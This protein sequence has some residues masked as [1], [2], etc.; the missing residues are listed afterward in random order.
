MTL[1][2]A[3]GLGYSIR[4]LYDPWRDRFIDEGCDNVASPTSLV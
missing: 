2:G 4:Q 1:N 3:R